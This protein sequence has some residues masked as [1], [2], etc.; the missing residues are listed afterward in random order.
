MLQ[1]KATKTKISKTLGR[2]RS[3]TRREIKRNFWADDAFPK[4]YAGYFEMA[5]IG[6]TYFFEP[7]LAFESRLWPARDH[8]GVS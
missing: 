4:T 5:V 7:H 2:D 8:E 3:T 6:A 1:A